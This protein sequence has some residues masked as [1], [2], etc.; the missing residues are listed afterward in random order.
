METFETSDGTEVLIVNS[1]E[2]GVKAYQAMCPI[3]RFCY[4]K[5]ATK[6]E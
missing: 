5:V 2:H 6:V 3:R 1:E 4:L